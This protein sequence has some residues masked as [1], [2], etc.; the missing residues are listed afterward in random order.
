M[1]HFRKIPRFYRIFMRIFQIQSGQDQNLERFSRKKTKYFPRFYSIFFYYFFSLRISLHHNFTHS[2]FGISI[3]CICF[4]DEPAK[5]RES[6]LDPQPRNSFW[7][8]ATVSCKLKNFSCGLRTLINVVSDH[9]PNHW[10][11]HQKFC[12]HLS[13]L[14]NICWW[15]P[16]LDVHERKLAI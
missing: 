7:L 6:Y 1:I 11:A 16:G 12:K 3:S 14:I 5:L 13:C 2:V 4:W 9:F 8:P 10:A 15:E